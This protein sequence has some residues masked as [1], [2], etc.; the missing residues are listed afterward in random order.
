MTLSS[1]TQSS[2]TSSGVSSIRCGTDWS[3]ANTYCNKACSNNGDCP[4]GMSCFAALSTTC[5]APATGSPTVSGSSETTTSQVS[6]TRCGVNWSDANTYCNKACTNDGDC[7]SGM[8]CYASLSPTCLAPVSA[9][10]G[11][12]APTATPSTVIRCGTDWANANSFCNPSCKN[13][14][15][16][17]DGMSCFADVAAVCTTP[18]AMS[19]A[20]TALAT[21]FAYR[22]FTTP[23]VIGYWP[24]W[25]PYSRPQNN[26]DKIDLNWPDGSIKS[27]DSFQDKTKCRNKYPNLLTSIA[28][29]G[30]SLSRY[31]SSVVANETL[32]RTFAK[33]IHNYMDLNGFDGLDIDYEYPGGGASCNVVSPDDAKNT[34]RFLQILRAELGADRLISFATAVTPDHYVQNGV[35]YVTEYAK[36]VSYF[37]LM[38]Y[39]MYS[40]SSTA[41]YSDFNSALNLPGP[42]V[43]WMVAAGVSKSQIVTGVPFY[44]HSWSVGSKGQYNGVFQACDKTGQDPANATPC[45]VRPGD[46]LDATPSC[47]TCNPK[48]CAFTGVWFYFNLR[49]FSGTQRN[50]PLSG[51]SLTVSN[52]WTRQY[53][54]WAEAPTLY[55]PSF[56]PTDS[57]GANVT[58]SPFPVYVS[59]EDQQS[60]YAKSKWSRANGLAGVMVWELSQDYEQ[61]LLSAMKAG[62]SGG[63]MPSSGANSSSTPTS[64]VTTSASATASS[65]S[66]SISVSTSAGSSIPLMSPTGS[67]SSVVGS[68]VSPSLATGS[69]SVPSISTSGSSASASSASGTLSATYRG[70]LTGS[71]IPSS[72]QP[73]ASPTVSPTISPSSQPSTNDAS[74][75]TWYY[76]SSG[77]S[78][79]TASS[80]ASPSPSTSPT[81]TGGSSSVVSTATDS[82]AGSALASS[83]SA[84]TNSVSSPATSIGASSAVP[85]SATGSPS[86]VTSSSSIVASSSPTSVP[87]TVYGGSS[88]A[89]TGVTAAG[90]PSSVVV[91]SDTAGLSSSGI[92]SSSTAGATSSGV[93]T[94]FS[95]SYGGSTTSLVGSSA[96]SLVSQSSPSSASSISTPASKPTT[97]PSPTSFAGTV[98]SIGNT[99]A[100]PSAVSYGSS[101]T[102]V[103]TSAVAGDSTSTSQ[104]TYGGNPVPTSTSAVAR[105]STQS[106]GASYGGAPNV[107]GGK[108]CA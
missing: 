41:P 3:N 34:V 81:V 45:D 84:A 42:S 73:S 62:W 96:P 95:S 18:T 105:V 68:S 8:G 24:N 15:D 17:P 97:A 103:T 52:G 12:S 43:E 66:L 72:W 58:S 49:G 64:T 50:A 9:G 13:N 78:A 70:G 88:V 83:S 101:P 25:A 11:S 26:I 38:S 44:G 91:N 69:S 4:S 19:T 10:T 36:Y 28:V 27:S 22:P 33:N 102:P 55:N 65:G 14:G 76:G 53:I 23:G 71:N 29:G 85:S 63:A 47:D 86:A 2:P 92:W 104:R 59:Y 7:L 20:P 37:G 21:P 39:D 40:T 5:T 75:S 74:T 56:L 48:S 99:S 93:V 30:W 61:E 87:S 46:Y 107:K 51:G 32:T 90:A 108:P 77:V 31:F 54:D 57:N 94:T 35:N 6:T 79:S 106:P 100:G 1:A 60:I 98:S 82:S 80:P 67:A 89:S 16:C